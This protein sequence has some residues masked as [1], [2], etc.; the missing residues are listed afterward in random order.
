MEKIEKFGIFSGNFA[1]P[2]VADLI[3]VKKFLPVP[4]T[5][6]SA[7]ICHDPENVFFNFSSII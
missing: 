6:F 2:E 3:R 7:Q 4:I 5:I 1:N